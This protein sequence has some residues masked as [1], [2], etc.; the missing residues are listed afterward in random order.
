MSDSEKEIEGVNSSKQI[1]QA[2]LSI[3]LP[4]FWTNY[5]EAWFLQAEAQFNLK[6][7]SRDSTKYEY[8]VASLPQEVIMT[9]WDKIK[10][11]NV[12]YTQLKQTL[13]QRHSISEEKKLE[14]LLSN[15]ELG[16]RKPSD[17]YRSMEILAGTSSTVGQDL[18][19][20]LW[21]KKLPPVINIALVAS[22]KS[23]L[24]EL[25]DM[26]D[27]IWDVSQPRQIHEM[28]LKPKASSIPPDLVD[29][30]SAL[31]CKYDEVKNEVAELK[32]IILNDRIHNNFQ[33]HENRRRHSSRSS[34]RSPIRY[35]SRSSSRTRSNTF[36]ESG[37]YCWYH[38]TYGRAANK[39]KQPCKFSDN[40]VALVN[41]ETKN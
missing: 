13:I 26:A 29:M 16:D 37:P 9:V 3:K 1:E 24:Q 14:E 10:N 41:N 15:T 8:V 35:S 28:I 5:P 6:G 20:Q 17:L 33:Q 25:A 23:N 12:S 40:K 2:S 4:I 31:A 39:C 38:Y 32:K 27:K 18:L 7:I 22:G 19:K 36:N 21:M 30:F 11:K 34:D